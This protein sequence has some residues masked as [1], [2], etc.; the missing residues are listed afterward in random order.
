MTLF[1]KILVPT[2][3]SDPSLEAFK[4]AKSLA[5]HLGAE[6]ILAHVI[7]PVPVQYPYPDPPVSS[8][9][10]VALYQQELAL[11][12]EKM[13]EQLAGQRA[14]KETRIRTEVVT[15]DPAHE[16]IR[17]AEVDHPDLIVIATH[18]RTGWR[19]LVFGSVAEKVIRLAP[20]P[21][22]TV[23]PPHEERDRSG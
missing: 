20:V 8:S 3:F 9:F 7:P 1:K 4:L 19:R 2:D 12:A 16:I 14:P 23:V 5:G 21:V 11:D 15:G 13:L 17:M 22:L 18:G 6:I 10:D